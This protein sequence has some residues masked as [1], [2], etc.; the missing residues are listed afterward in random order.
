MIVV[1]IYS[2]LRVY[3]LFVAQCTGSSLR[4]R[5]RSEIIFMLNIRVFNTV[6]LLLVDKIE[7]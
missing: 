5:P 6:M 3:I 2:K 1:Y 4:R 7:Y